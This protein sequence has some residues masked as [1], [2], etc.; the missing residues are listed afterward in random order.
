MNAFPISANVKHIDQYTY[1]TAAFTHAQLLCETGP[2]GVNNAIELLQRIIRAPLL[3]K[4]RRHKITFHIDSRSAALTASVAQKLA[5]LLYN[6]TYHPDSNQ[7]KSLLDYALLSGALPSSEQTKA[8]AV[9]AFSIADT[10]NDGLDPQGHRSEIVKALA[11]AS[12][13]GCATAG[14]EL[15]FLLRSGQY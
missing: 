8:A 10:P 1:L 15:A 6:H 2:V 3:S 14:N 9:L 7:I 5:T 11:R 4:T 13:L 12:K